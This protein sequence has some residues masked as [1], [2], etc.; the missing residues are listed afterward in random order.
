MSDLFT[1]YVEHSLLIK[2]IVI[3]GENRQFY[4]LYKTKSMKHFKKTVMRLTLLFIQ[5]VWHYR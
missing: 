1:T 4:A 5:Q 2:A 3:I